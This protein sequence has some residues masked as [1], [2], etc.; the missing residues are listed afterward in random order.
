[1][2][3]RYQAVWRECTG[4]LAGERYYTVCVVHLDD[5]G[6]L[7]YW[8]ENPEVTASGDTLEE[9]RRDIRRMYEACGNW[10]PV[11]FEYLRP[12]MTFKRRL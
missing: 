3:W 2:T 8:S 11:A 5:D 1:M 6:R 7:E 10:E 9:L 4:Y 12:G